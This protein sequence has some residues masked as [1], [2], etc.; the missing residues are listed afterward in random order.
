MQV[1]FPVPDKGNWGK[2]KRVLSYLKGTIHMPL[3]LS[4]DSLMLSRW[5]V[6]AAYAVHN[7]CRGHKGQG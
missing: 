7:N 6:D 3:I 5:W 2:A 4:A 1:R